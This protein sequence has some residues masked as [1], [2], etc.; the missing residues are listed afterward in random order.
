MSLSSSKATRCAGIAVLCGVGAAAPVARAAAPCAEPVTA[1]AFHQVVSLADAAYSQ[2]DLEG[3][4]AARLQARQMVPCL[5]EPITPAQAAG[6]HRLEALGE[7][8]GRNHAGSV[9]ALRALASAAPGYE[10][11]E[12]LAPQG[13]PLQMYYEI[14]RGTVSVAPVPIPPEE[15]RWFHIDG[16][17]ATERP[18]DRPYLFQSFEEGGRVTTS[19]LVKAGK[20]PPGFT[21]PGPDLPRVDRKRTARS[22]AWVSVGSAAVAGGLYLG[23]RSASNKFWDPT[24]PRSDL[25]ALRTRTNALG[26]T[27]A[28]VGLVAMGTG[29][30][31]LLVGTW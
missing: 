7:F 8:L 28:G 17:A 12:E 27:S 2:M 9:S 6:F 31:A 3:F 1:R 21:A 20:L 22:L 11:S 5:A 10:L 29:G 24:T 14:A 13:H 18:I 4:Q 26:W 15:G 19:S 30:A 23:A 25:D 16:A